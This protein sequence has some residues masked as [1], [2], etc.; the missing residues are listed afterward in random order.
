MRTSG[1]S[2]AHLYLGNKQL[3]PRP[4]I[5]SQGR[6]S[7]LPFLALRGRLSTFLPPQ[8]HLGPQDPQLGTTGTFPGVRI[9]RMYHTMLDRV[10]EVPGGLAHRLLAEREELYLCVLNWLCK[11]LLEAQT[12]ILCRTDD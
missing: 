8:A 9:W 3:P 12:L 4:H 2:L 10:S 5:G 1:A 6:Q 7:D 11:V